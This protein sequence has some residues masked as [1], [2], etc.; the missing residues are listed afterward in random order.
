MYTTENHTPFANAISLYPDETGA[1]AIFATIRAT[2]ILEDK[3]YLQKP[4]PNVELADVYYGDPASTSLQYA[5][6]TH[7]GKL[8]TDVA[9]VGSAVSAQPT[10]QMTVSAQVG[11]LHRSIRVWGDREIENGHQTRPVPFHEMPVIYENAFGGG[12]KISQGRYE[13][14]EANPVGKG[15]SVKLAAR[16]RQLPNLTCIDGNYEDR[17]PACFGFVA[18]HWS[19]RRSQAGTYDDKWAETRAPFLPQDFDKRFFNSAHTDWIYSGFMKGDEYFEIS[20]MN[21][22]GIVAGEL[23]AVGIIG[24]IAN[25][26]EVSDLGFHLETVLFEPNERKVSL[27]WKTKYLLG[28][29]P[30]KHTKITLHQCD[31]Y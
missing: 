25:G 10:E 2:F 27:V 3:W 7:C 6:E 11:K 28:E 12:E 21:A 14:Y 15:F 24:S 8:S 5:S 13:A 1:D 23:P 30:G 19:R 29:L 9:I 4:Q 18:P 16:P 20:G 22:S 31:L 26:S 17:A